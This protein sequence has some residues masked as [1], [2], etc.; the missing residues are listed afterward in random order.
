MLSA[1]LTDLQYT[2]TKSLATSLAL[3]ITLVIIY[4]VQ[5]YLYILTC[6]NK[7]DNKGLRQIVFCLILLLK[8]AKLVLR[9]WSKKKSHAG[10]FIVYNTLT[11]SSTL[12][13]FYRFLNISL[14]ICLNLIPVTKY[15]PLLFSSFN[16]AFLLQTLKCHI[17]FR[18][19]QP[20][21]SRLW[22]EC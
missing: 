17:W 10:I 3:K 11:Q 12:V 6:I 15:V 22:T 13:I 14:A 18:G 19:Y 4:Y 21:V 5:L 8:R 20:L 1:F 9:E 2:L 16:G 7:H